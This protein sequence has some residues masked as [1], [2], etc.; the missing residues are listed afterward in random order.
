MAATTSDKVGPTHTSETE[1]NCELVL[2]N[3]VAVMCNL[4]LATKF[5]PGQNYDI[6]LPTSATEHKFV[7]DNIAAELTDLT[8]AMRFR[9][10]QIR[11]RFV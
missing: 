4:S 3:I 6:I 1:S 7:L 10:G 5:C 11:H 8:V 9:P 2:D